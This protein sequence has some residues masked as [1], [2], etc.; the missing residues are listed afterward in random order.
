MKTNLELVKGLTGYDIEVRGNL[1]IISRGTPENGE[2]IELNNFN[3]EA[4][5]GSASHYRNGRESICGWEV[6]GNGVKFIH[7]EN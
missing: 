5:E 2:T 3:S 6:I 7:R 4:T 1:V